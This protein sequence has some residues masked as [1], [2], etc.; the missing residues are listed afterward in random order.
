MKV[1]SISTDN[2]IFEENSAVFERQNEY[3]KKLDEL[4]IIV[5]TKKK[6][7]EKHLGN[8]HIYPTNSFFKIGFVRNAR[9]IAEKILK[10]RSGFVVTTQDPF[11]TALVGM[12]I[13]KKFNTPFQ[14]QVHTD[15]LSPYFKNGFLNRLRILIS[16]I[17]IPKADGIRVVSSAIMDSIKEKFPKL[18]SKI[19]ILPIFVDFEINDEN[20]GSGSGAKILIV[21]RLEKEKKV[22]TA[23]KVFKKVSE[24][25]SNAELVI[26]GDGSLRG[27]LENIKTELN[28]KRVTFLGWVDEV[29]SLF[30]EADIF[31]FTSE[32]E[33]YGM[34]LIEAGASGCPIVTTE[35]GIAKTALFKDNV[36]SFVCP[37]GDVDC[38]S[39]AIIMLIE[40]FEKRKLFAQRMQDSIKNTII[41]KEEYISRYVKIMSNLL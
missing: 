3:A 20:R 23:L 9:S 39:K 25:N 28:L 5:F 17:T 40:D 27:R 13:K 38:L 41:S 33:G 2:K 15:F 12:G 32:Y 18:K 16:N 4:H 1:L 36:N 10:D 21:S 37:V 26:A 30:K 6:F 22:D 29:K 8:L 7:N 35:V 31:L 11:E 34:T 14:I 19:D 24:K